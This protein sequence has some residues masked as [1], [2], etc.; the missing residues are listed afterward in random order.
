MTAT[1]NTKPIQSKLMQPYDWT[2]ILHIPQGADRGEGA[3]LFRF[4]SKNKPYTQNP[5]TIDFVNQHLSKAKRLQ[6]DA[7]VLRFASDAVTLPNGAYLDMGVCTGKSVNF[8]AAL[9]PHQI[10]HGFD[11][12]EGLPE[13]WVRKDRVWE[14]GTFAFKEGTTLPPVLNNVRLYPGLFKNV[15]PTFKSS[16]L[17]DQPIAVL[18]IDCELYR[19]TKDVLD[20]L[21]DNLIPGSIIVFDELYNYPGFEDHEWRAFQEFIAD[22]RFKFEFMAFNENHEQV[23]LKIV[24]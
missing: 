7:E 16:I 19:S 20:I 21:G 11:S 15:L 18:H 22:R 3:Q 24:K 4:I 9:N 14:K 23:A 17:K 8:I 2:Q 6:S 5:E 10:I 12:F 13:D 1:L